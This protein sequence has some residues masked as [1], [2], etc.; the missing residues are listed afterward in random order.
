MTPRQSEAQRQASQNRG[1]ER[2][3][4]CHD[5]RCQELPA[6]A[7][8]H[9]RLRRRPGRSGPRVDSLRHSG[10]FRGRRVSRARAGLPGKFV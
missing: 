2:L 1:H 5:D 3:H 9:P 7:Y 4:P 6:E 8:H 10:P